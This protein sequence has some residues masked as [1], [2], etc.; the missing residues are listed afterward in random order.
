MAKSV[1][2]GDRVAW[3]SSG[4]ESVGRVEKKL[5]SPG[6]I[7]THEVAASE[8]NPEYLV[9]SEKSGKAAAHKPSS[10]RKAP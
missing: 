7:K 5:T 9:R 1:K 4:G 3:S 6:W 8:E 2:P 10:L